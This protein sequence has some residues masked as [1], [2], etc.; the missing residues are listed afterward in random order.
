[1]KPTTQF[2]FLIFILVLGFSNSVSGQTGDRR[3]YIEVPRENAVLVVASQP[4][5]PLEFETPTL[6]MGIEGS[7][8]ALKGNLRNR[9]IKPISSFSFA[10]WNSVGGGWVDSWPRKITTEVLGPGQTL[11][12]ATETGNEIVP[13]TADL[14]Q[15]LK[16]QGPMRGVLVAMIVQVKFA[17]GTSYSDE[18]IFNALRDYLNNVQAK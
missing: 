11:P 2:R 14:R 6:L 1:M 18:P 5:C 10:L 3:P 9:G 17:D 15:K 4:N 7:G 12:L 13:L 8:L 16:L